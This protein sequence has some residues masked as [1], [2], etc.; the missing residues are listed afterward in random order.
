MVIS[1]FKFLAIYYGINLDAGMNYSHKLMKKEFK[2][3]KRCSFKYAN[4]NQELL[5][6]GKIIYVKDTYDE[7]IP[8]I[9]PNKIECS[10]KECSYTKKVIN[11]DEVSKKEIIEEL[12]KLP[13]YIVHELLSKYKNKPSFYKIIKKELIARGIYENKKYKLEKEINL[14]EGDFD[15]KYQRRRKIKYKKS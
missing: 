9:C 1:I 14:E 13:N 8:Y 15:D 4:N 3:L 11:H 6:D 12:D 5:N 10:N 7:I 2:F